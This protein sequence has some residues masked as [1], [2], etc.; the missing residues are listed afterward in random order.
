MNE[1]NPPQDRP[2]PTVRCAGIPLTPLAPAAA[3][4]AVVRLAVSG[5]GADVHLCGTHTLARA[6]RDPELRRTLRSAAL[7]LPAG[8]GAAWAGRIAGRGPSLPPVRVY[9]PDLLL[10]TVRAGRRE[11]LRHYVLGGGTDP[12]ALPGTGTGREALEQLTAELLVRYPETCVAGAEPGPGRELTA[13]ERAALA[14]RI[15]DSGAQLVWIGGPDT[16][17][18]HRTAT[19]LAA[20]HPA[21][22]LA[23]GTAFDVLCDRVPRLP[24]RQRCQRGLSALR[25]GSRLLR[26]AAKEAYGSRGPYRELAQLLTDAEVDLV[27]DAGAGDGAYAVG[28]R[29]AGYRGRIVSLEVLPGLR[30]QLLR[31]AAADP[32][33]AVLPYALGDGAGP[34]GGHRLDELWDTVTAPGERLFVRLRTPGHEERL[35]YGA[36]RYATECVGLQTRGER[37][38]PVPGYAAV[39]AWGGGDAVLFR[40]GGV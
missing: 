26:A 30:E 18:Q 4:A 27:L 25:G 13:D 8:P 31:R 32:A 1:A 9:G 35:L 37:A 23:V 10:D 29:R 7:N 22:Y 36:G 15:R 21:V 6:D 24:V 34:D 16:A 40:R 28:L 38:E 20:A 3:A 12:D 14:A 11:G 19:R 17:E 33:W 2:Y 39:P 5:A